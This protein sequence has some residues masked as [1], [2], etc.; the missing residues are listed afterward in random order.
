MWEALSPMCIDKR[1]THPL[2]HCAQLKIT[3]RRYAKHI[4]FNTFQF[5]GTKRKHQ[6]HFRPLLRQRARICNSEC[7]ETR[8][9]PQ[10]LCAC[11]LIIAAVSFFLLTVRPP[12]IRYCAT[13]RG[14][15]KGIPII[16][17]FTAAKLPECVQTR[18]S[19]SLPLS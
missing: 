17:I 7:F 19:I 4:A 2:S 16:I 13:L 6:N 15:D 1:E 12:A 14:S 10:P 3:G 9:F 18:G 11:N 5:T 8:L